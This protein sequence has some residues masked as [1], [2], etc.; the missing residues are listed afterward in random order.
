MAHFEPCAS[1]PLHGEEDDNTRNVRRTPAGFRRMVHALM[2]GLQKPMLARDTELALIFRSQGGDLKATEDLI[3]AHKGYLAAA[4]RVH[5]RR[6]ERE[7]DPSDLASVALQGFLK[8]IDRYVPEAG[9]RLATFADYHVTG[10][11]KQYILDFS[12]PVRIGTNSEERRAWTQLS[13][14][15]RAFREAYGRDMQDTIEDC[16]RAVQFSKPNAAGEPIR[17]K[18]LF[19]LLGAMRQRYSVS[20]DDVQIV[21]PDPSSCGETQAILGDMRMILRAQLEQLG[22]KLNPRDLEIVTYIMSNPDDTSARRQEMA[23]R[24][25]MTAERVGQIY[26]MALTDI[27]ANLRKAGIRQASDMI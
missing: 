12:G 24:H 8:A 19:N 27:R 11:V 13:R 2:S 5:A 18:S 14:L 26:R 17:A 23:K 21:A 25:K 4:I 3:F 6:A 7:I 15:R 16:E 22:D 10:A 20:V 1:F 9:A